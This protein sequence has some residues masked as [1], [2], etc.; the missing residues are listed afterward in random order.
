MN[1]EYKI[2]EGLKNDFEK[3]A[4]QLSDNGWIWC[5]NITSVN[6]E[7][8]VIHYLLMSRPKTL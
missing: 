8:G 3:E 4:N 5:G 6:T 1:T 2:V 7:K